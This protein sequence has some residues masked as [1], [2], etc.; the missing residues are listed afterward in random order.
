[1]S[2]IVLG[3]FYPLTRIFS[4]ICCI[5]LDHLQR[6]LEILQQCAIDQFEQK[7]GLFNQCTFRLLAS[8]LNQDQTQWASEKLSKVLPEWE[9]IYGPSHP[10]SL[11]LRLRLSETSRCSGR[12]FRAI[13]VAQNTLMVENCSDDTASC[14]W[15]EIACAQY[16]LSQMD[17]ALSS[18]DQ[19]LH[20]R[21]RRYGWSD[22]RIIS[23]LSFRVCLLKEMGKTQEAA[24]AS[25]QIRTLQKE[26]HA[27]LC[28]ED[29]MRHQ[30]L[31]AF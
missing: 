26:S 24:C 21:A 3:A 8:S 17:A 10:Q 20:M 4:Q 1:M 30:R 22:V 14:L 23:W 19:A 18:L 15:V 13:G 11:W 29:E 6:A 9:R 2:S 16:G 7:L 12:S 5:D 28:I 27:S 25:Q 31:R